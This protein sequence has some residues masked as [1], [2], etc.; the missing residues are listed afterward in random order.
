[1]EKEKIDRIITSSY[2]FTK[3]Y[4]RLLD[5]IQVDGRV[6]ITRLNNAHPPMTDEVDTARSKLYQS[7]EAL[8]D[9]EFFKIANFV[10]PGIYLDSPSTEIR[11]SVDRVKTRTALTEKLV[12][13][14][15]LFTH[16]RDAEV[17]LIG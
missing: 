13:D 9:E 15:L 2:E 16:L 11:Q 6:S 7:L 1:M 14:L 8:T 5:S 12:G 4:R 17:Q 3:A 10:F